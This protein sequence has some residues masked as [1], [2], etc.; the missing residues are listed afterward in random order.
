MA[1]NVYSLQLLRNGSVYQNKAAAIA[2]LQSAQGLADVVKKDGVPVLARYLETVD[3]SPVVKTLIGF[4]AKASEMSAAGGGADYMTIMDFDTSSVE[5]LE[6][7]VTA[8][9]EA[10]GDGFDSGNT[11]ADNI[12]EIENTLGTGVTTAN[13]VSDQLSALS[14]STAS[15]SADTSVEGAKK[16]ADAKIA[17]AVDGLDY[18]GVT[19]GTGVYVTNVTEE[20]GVVAATTATLPTV[21]TITEAGKPIVAV[22]ES[23]GAISASAGTINAE[24]VNVTDSGNLFSASTVE[25]VLAEIDAAYKA[26][27]QAIVGDATTSGDTLGKLEDR[28]DALDADAK[29]YHIVKET[30]GLPTEIKERY[31]LVDADGNVSGDT[32]DIPKDSHIVSITYITGSTDPHYQNLEYVYIDASGNT[33]TEYVDM[34]KL[35]LESEFASGVTSTNGV[36]HGVVDPTSETFLTVGADGFKLSGVQTAIN[37]AVEDLDADVSGSSTHVSVEVVEADGVITTVT[38]TE[39]DIASADDLEELSGKTLTEVES[40]NSSISAV[41]AATTDGTVKVDLVTDASKI[42]MSGFTA[43]TSGFTAISESDSVVDAFKDVEAF[44]LDNELVV[45]TALNDLEDRKADKTY[46]D[47]EI[48]SAS[49][50]LQT[51]IDSLTSGS[52]EALDNEIAARKAIEGQSGDTYTANSSSPYISGASNMNDADVKLAE[53]LNGVDERMVSG[54]TMNGSA[55]TKSDESL[56]FTAVASQNAAPSGSTTAIVIDTDANGGLTFSLGTLDVG[57]YDA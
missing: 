24:Y 16:Y 15:T 29:E 34:S 48:L 33:K 12:E 18:S 31:S 13:T 55:V 8:L 17:E 53:A 25:G 49:G 27:D 36:V 40:S 23:L 52:T 3:N 14:G 32:I 9:E 2:A 10:L 30:N 54:A 6:N 47:D 22:S 26:A 21:A 37:S 57:F 1:K 43:D 4:Y 51:Q 39:D 5:A 7:K 28:I 20:N 35:V 50:N 42:Q 38:V 41:T 19:T 56:A 44:V 46:V 45:S 11:V